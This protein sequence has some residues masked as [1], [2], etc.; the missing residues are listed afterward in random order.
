MTKP[1]E[2]IEY[3]R[4]KKSPHADLLI[5]DG[6]D[7][8]LTPSPSIKDAAK[9]QAE[10]TWAANED[11]IVVKHQPAIAIYVSTNDGV[12]IRQEDFWG[13]GSDQVVYFTPNHAEKIA[14]A[15]LAIAKEIK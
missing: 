9:P 13:D 14:K 1:D 2:I 11:C 8:K 3:T 4:D 5:L 15:I 7:V 12:C 6:D 10:F